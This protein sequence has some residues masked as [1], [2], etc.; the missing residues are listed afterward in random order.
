M[1]VIAALFALFILPGSAMAFWEG[2]KMI[3]S[4]SLLLKFLIIGIAIGTIIYIVLLGRWNYFLTFEHEFTHAFMSLLFFRS[5]E[6]FIVTSR[7]GGYVR[8]SGGF[9][10]EF[11]NIMIS[12]A[13]YYLPTYTIILLLFQPLIPPNFLPV[14][15]AASG[16][17]FVFHFLSTAKELKQNWSS[18]SFNIAR[19]NDQTNNDSS[20]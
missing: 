4:D 13:P 1:R 7:E 2:L 14:F 17:T 18:E 8:Y 12:L 6:R 15:F 3:N 5:I 19:T 11:G 10:G 16:F 20:I 9:G